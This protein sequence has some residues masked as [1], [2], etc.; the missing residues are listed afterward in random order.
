MSASPAAEVVVGVH[1]VEARV[2]ADPDS[3]LRLL[4]QDNR[5]DGRIAGVVAAARAAG[6][7]VDLVP[8]RRL[9]QH[10][11]QLRHQGLVA[12]CRAQPERNAD[13]LQQAL[14]HLPNPLLLVL[15]GVQDPRNLGACLRSAAAAGVDGVITPRDRA[16]GL[17]PAARKAAAGAAE[18]LPLYRVTNL[19]RCLRAL[20]EA[21]VRIVGA[22]AEAPESLYVSD[23]TGPL[24][25]VMG[26]EE[27]GL[28]RLTR[29]HC[30]S[31]VHIPLA[32]GSESLN[33]SVAAGVCLFEVVRQ[34]GRL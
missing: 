11:P 16:A 8:R 2:T 6:I 25:L 23:L 31:L 5:R 28:R 1:A 3:V 24:A 22:D 32:P 27:K 33:V 7:E 14:E 21:G 12:E 10:Y 9:D 18:Q 4:V 30:D 17:T 19:A 26:A 29:E 34:R 20:A 13:D 15:D